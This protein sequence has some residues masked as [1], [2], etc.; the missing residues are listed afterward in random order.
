M[1]STSSPF[2]CR[3][4]VG[5]KGRFG[6]EFMEFELKEEVG[7]GGRLRYANN[8]QYKN[9]VLI[10]KECKVH[11]AVLEEV[12]RIVRESTVLSA[13]DGEW[14]EPDRAGRQELEIVLDDEHISFTCSK[15]GSLTEIAAST[16]PETLRN[17][18]YLTQDLKCLI[19]SIVTC[20]FKVRILLRCGVPCPYFFFL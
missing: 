7:V 10:R 15:L 16:N 14:P 2:Y 12:K 18:Y 13:D 5:H 8:S 9:D 19:F 4:Y 11:R 3:Y 20:H 6:H 1:S 17:F